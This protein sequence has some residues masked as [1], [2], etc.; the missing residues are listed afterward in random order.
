MIN[1]TL[2]RAKG[3]AGPLVSIS[4]GSEV[5][6]GDGAVVSGSNITLY[7][8]IIELKNGTLN[9]IG[10]AICDIKVT[11]GQTKHADDAI[12]ITQ[13]AI[14]SNLGIYRGEIQGHISCLAQNCNIDIEGGEYT[15]IPTCPQNY[16]YS[17]ISSNS[18]I[19]LNGSTNVGSIEV[20]QNAKVLLK[21]K[22][23]YKTGLLGTKDNA[24]I[25][26]YNYSISN[27][28][29]KE[30]YC[31]GQ[32]FSYNDFKFELIDNTVYIRAD[33]T[34]KTAD[35]LQAKLNE[36]ASKGTST[37]SKPET[38]K[39]SPNGILIDKVINV[40]EKCHAVLTG[41]NIK[42][43]PQISGHY[44]FTMYR[45]NTSIELKDINIDCNNVISEQ[46]TYYSGY[47]YLGSDSYV[48]ST[49]LTIGSGVNFI[50][51]NKKSKIHIAYLAGKGSYIDWINGKHIT[52]GYAI[53]G[54][55]SV[56]LNN[57]TIE[58]QGTAIEGNYV[59]LS[60]TTVVS[61]YN[62]V[63]K[64]NSFSIQ[65]E[66]TVKCL[67]KGGKFLS[68]KYADSSFG[69]GQFIGDNCWIEVEEMLMIPRFQNLNIYLHANPNFKVLHSNESQ[70]N[71]VFVIDGDWKNF[72]LNKVFI[73]DLEK[74][75]YPYIKF[76][77]I[78]DD[79]E[80]YYN[81][82]AKTVSLRKKT[83]DGD[84][85]QDFINGLTGGNKGTEKGP[86]GID[87][88]SGGVSID[89]GTPTIGN[90]EDDL[91]A[92]IDGKKSDGSN[93]V[94]RLTGNG[95]FK[96]DQYCTLRISN[97]DF[98]NTGNGYIYVSGTLII[99]IN[100]N[101]TII[102]QLIRVLPGGRVIWNGGGGKGTDITKE[103]IYVEWNS[104]FEYRG[105]TISGGEYGFH[106]WGTTYIYDGSIGGTKWSGYTYE[107][108]TTYIYGGQFIGDFHNG[109]TTTITGGTFGN[110][111][112]GTIYNDGTLNIGGSGWSGGTI[113][114]GS[115]G[116]I[117]IIGKLNIVIR[118]HIS[119]N[120]IVLG[121]PI[122]LGGNGYVLTEDDLKK[123]QI[124]LP[125]GYTWKYDITLHAI[126][127]V[128]PTG[129][130]NIISDTDDTKKQYFDMG[131]NRLQKPQKGVN[132]VRTSDGK[133]KKVV[134]K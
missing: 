35:D 126:I 129:I 13:D 19:K 122:I 52:G 76:I 105:G 83:Y 18:N 85:L 42:I 2:S 133:V 3:L 17:T 11:I 51:V 10:G 38:I 41:G 90:G 91:Q 120:D 97:I 14:N 134:V 109:G 69:Q 58:S 99:D 28:D 88:P 107:N 72:S 15:G 68:L 55:G 104:T 125:D 53:C 106:G 80:I 127:I 39:I 119:I 56:H 8:P 46:N 131:G 121:T 65:T 115:H 112:N 93:T 79:R 103:F 114:N 94:F 75:D 110:G 9:I 27:D 98:S 92:F 66:A 130:E 67:T 25:E 87:L 86:V 82:K 74:D 4:N 77:N 47:F 128:A 84:D 100:I 62:T 22:L 36:I 102:R 95:N 73:S 118:I 1:G 101:I 111:G 70:Y 57:V 16:F 21:T 48:N 43:A 89:N 7:K 33:N 45:G 124:V 23:K 44:V 50:N 64:S 40:P 29:I 132:I 24:V 34:I 37:T 12:N 59:G 117:Y 81:E 26:G 108:S 32:N 116:R 71:G 49:H 6:L 123:I 54:K 20:G 60:G 63:I 5:E 96:V 78:P 31:G 113:Y 61:G 30:L